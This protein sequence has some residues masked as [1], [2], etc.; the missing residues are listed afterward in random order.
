MSHALPAARLLDE[1]LDVL[2]RIIVSGI[3]GSAPLVRRCDALGE[4]L[5]QGGLAPVGEHLRVVA[6][7]DGDRG[8]V[9]AAFRALRSVKCARLRLAK[10]ARVDMGALEPSR[11][12]AHILVERP[13][14]P[15]AAEGSVS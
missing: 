15:E 5:K 11:A 2:G 10:P 3:C 14:S 13:E 9:A 8:T 12:R 4:A 1:A 7:G 6:A